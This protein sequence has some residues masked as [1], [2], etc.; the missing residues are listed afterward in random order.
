MVTARII[1]MASTFLLVSWKSPGP[2]QET[3]Q[4]LGPL[5]I[6]DSWSHC[7]SQRGSV[8]SVKLNSTTALY[9]TSLSMLVDGNL[10]GVQSPSPTTSAIRKYTLSVSLAPGPHTFYLLSGPSSSQTYSLQVLS[11][12]YCQSDTPPEEL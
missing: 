2:E 5:I 6:A 7:Y 1:L 4:L 8:V 10:T 9:Y 12:V 11:G 3:A